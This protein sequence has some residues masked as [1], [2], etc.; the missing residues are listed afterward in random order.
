[1]LVIIYMNA[2]TVFL[3]RTCPL[4][5]LEKHYTNTTCLKSIF[6]LKKDEEKKD[7]KEKNKNKNKDKVLST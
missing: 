2:I 6:F 1:M 4:V 3:L 5:L 7:K